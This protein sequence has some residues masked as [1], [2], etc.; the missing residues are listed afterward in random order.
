MKQVARQLIEALVAA[1]PDHVL[2]RLGHEDIPGLDEALAAGAEWLGATLEDLLSRP[3]REQRRGPL[4]VFQEAMRFPTDHLATLGRAPAERDPIAKSALPGDLY[5]LAP[6]ST[7]DLGEEVWGRHL[8]WGA[9]KA[10][11][12]LTPPPGSAPSGDVR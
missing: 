9:A 6:A 8:A 12:A 11:D 10:A 1:Y 5:D 4:E 2:T 7:Q 3:F